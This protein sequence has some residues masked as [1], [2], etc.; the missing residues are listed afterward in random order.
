MAYPMRVKRSRPILVK[1]APGNRSQARV[2]FG[3]GVRPAAL[4]R[5]GIRA[6]KREGDGGTPLGRFPVRQVFY[7][8]DRVPRPRTMLPVRAINDRDGWCD[9]PSDRNYNRLIRLPSLRSA[10]GLKRA[11][12]VYDLV[13]VLGYNDRPRVKGKGSAIFVHLA[14]PGYTPTDGCIALTRHD[15]TIL[16][17]SLRPGTTI[18]VTR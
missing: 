7:R 2:L 10:E 14:R 1:S 11:D 12:Q 13:L 8:S 9:D 16:L 3:H 4:G 5:T 6:L 17:A 18:I 15:L